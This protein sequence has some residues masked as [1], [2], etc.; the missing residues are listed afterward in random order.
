M[1]FDLPVSAVATHTSPV[2][3]MSIAEIHTSAIRPGSPAGLSAVAVVNEQ[4]PSR[5]TRSPVNV[6]A[7]IAPSD[8]ILYC[9]SNVPPY[10]M[11]CSQTQRNEQPSSWLTSSPKVVA[12]YS[13]WLSPGRNF[14]PLVIG[15][16]PF[17]SATTGTRHAATAAT[18][19]MARL[20]L[21]RRTRSCARRTP[22]SRRACTHTRRNKSSPVSFIDRLRDRCQALTLDASGGS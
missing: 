10:P 6:V 3:P 15:G 13:E 19:R 11:F 18:E 7:K 21:T 22:R 17:A 4:P 16:R 2:G 12:T 5:L 1:L 8:A 14:T 20:Y 9:G